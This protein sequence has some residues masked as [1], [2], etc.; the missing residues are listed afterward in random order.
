[1]KCIVLLFALSAVCAVYS[2]P[3][4]QHGNASVLSNPSHTNCA[5]LRDSNQVTVLFDPGMFFYQQAAANQYRQYQPLHQMYMQYQ[6]PYRAAAQRRS[7]Y[8]PS[9]GIS[10]YVAG[11]Q[12]AASGSFL[13]GLIARALTKKL[14]P[15]KN[16]FAKQIHVTTT[17][18]YSTSSEDAAEQAEPE[19]LAD[20]IPVEQDDDAAVSIAEAYPAADD[21]E[22]ADPAAAAADEPQHDEVPEFLEL[23]LAPIAP[24]A[25]ALPQ[26]PAVAALV[27]QRKKKNQVTVQLDTSADEEEVA[28]QQDEI[29]VYRKTQRRPAYGGSPPS[30]PINTYFPIN[31]GNTNG[32]AIA[33]ANAYST[34][35]KGGA[36][37]HAIAYGSPA[38]AAKKQ[39]PR[40]TQTQAIAA[41]SA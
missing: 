33:V 7:A 31:F 12:V 9:S 13:K 5:K 38:S 18:N 24:V 40:K 27:P 22:Q 25:D 11:N 4:P 39:K 17:T 36:R 21:E 14:T 2:V 20:D 6:Q 32:G 8:V 23:P 29:P 34:G 3:L 16:W 26:L 1:M 35:Q 15:F 37:S 28:I 41:N 30:N 19:T 10:A